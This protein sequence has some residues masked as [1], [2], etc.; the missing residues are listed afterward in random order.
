[1]ISSITEI[2]ELKNNDVDL[3]ELNDYLFNII[4]EIEIELKSSIRKN[5]DTNDNW[6]KR[7]NPNFMSSFVNKDKN[8]LEINCAL[9]KITETNYELIVSEII[10]I[11]DKCSEEDSEK[12]NELLNYICDSLYDKSI[13][14]NIFIKYYII[15]LKKISNYKNNNI[16]ETK[17]KEL[18]D[19]FNKFITDDQECLE[20]LINKKINDNNQYKNIGLFFAQYTL[21]FKIKNNFLLIDDY[22]KKINTFLSWQPI[23]KNNLEINLNLLCSFLEELSDDFLTYLSRDEKNNILSKVEFLTKNKLIPIKMR[24]QIQDLH[25]KISNV[26]KTEVIIEENTVDRSIENNVNNITHVVYDK[27]KKR[28]NRNN[29]NSKYFSKG[30]NRNNGLNENNG[31]NGNNRNLNETNAS[32]SSYSGRKDKNM[33][34]KKKY[35]DNLN[36]KRN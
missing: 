31:N 27:K 28:Q 10:N 3:S 33:E 36:F 29:R 6:R 18:N 13:I 11:L 17:L 21:Q 19:S 23:N 2:Y 20:T 4:S 8:I 22:L 34:S 5:Y 35:Y 24:F 14:Q 7:K 15:F 26:K 1:M 16:I 12:V 25:E 30:A 32:E 9:N